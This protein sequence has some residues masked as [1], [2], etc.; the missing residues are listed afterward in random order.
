[1]GQTISHTKY[2]FIEIEMGNA[3]SINSITKKLKS[4]GVE[5]DTTFLPKA[6]NVTQSNRRK[7]F[8]LKVKVVK[9]SIKELNNCPDVINYWELKP[10][11]PFN[12]DNTL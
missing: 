3:N 5:I 1:M 10:F 6:L 9:S 8:L 2:L 7:L 12:N 4:I 11:I